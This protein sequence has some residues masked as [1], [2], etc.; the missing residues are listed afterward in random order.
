VT[1]HILLSLWYSIKLLMKIL[2]QS[3]R[4]SEILTLFSKVK[5]Y[6]PASSVIILM[7]FFKKE[8]PSVYGQV[9][10][11]YIF[12]EHFGLQSSINISSYFILIYQLILA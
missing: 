8:N 6:C 4:R 3:C 2:D 10:A 11:L 1:Y 5:L 9:L 12:A 7:S